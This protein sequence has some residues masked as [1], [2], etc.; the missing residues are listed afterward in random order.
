MIAHFT[1]CEPLAAPD[2]PVRI[3]QPN[4]GQQDKWREGFEERNF[5]RLRRLSGQAGEEPRL[6]LWPEAAV[7]YP[8]QDERAHPHYGRQPDQLRARVWRV[9]CPRR[10]D[11]PQLGNMGGLV[12]CF[13][14]WP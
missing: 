5:A 2:L 8:L 3:V 7:T 6:L 12:V 4:I 1:R 10:S 13:F 14:F 11:E 9:F